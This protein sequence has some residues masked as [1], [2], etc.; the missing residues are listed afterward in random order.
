MSEFKNVTPI[1]GEYELIDIDPHFTRVVKYFRASDY[2]RWALFTA[3]APLFLVWSEHIQ[4][5]GKSRKV[6]PRTFRIAT[7]IG[8]A[9]GF[10]FSYNRSVQR[11][12]GIVENAPEVTKDRYEIKSRLSK[13]LKPYGDSDLAPW[14]QR[15]AARNSTYSSTFTHVFPWFNLVNHEYHGVDLKKYYE[16]REGEEKWGFDLKLPTDEE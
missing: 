12:Q 1:K 3:S 9:S 10:I 7:F 14:L 4:S 11:F 2:L 8:L 15:V 16:V 6:S 5:E 13:G